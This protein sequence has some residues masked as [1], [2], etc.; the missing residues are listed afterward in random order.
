MSE[1]QQTTVDHFF[2]LQK[3]AVAVRQVTEKNASLARVADPLVAKQEDDDAESQARL[4]A[5]I[6]KKSLLA[7]TTTTTTTGASL[8]RKRVFSGPIEV[9]VII[10][11]PKLEA[12][13]EDQSQHASSPAK[14]SKTSPPPAP[15]I[16]SRTTISESAIASSASALAQLQSLVTPKGTSSLS[17]TTTTT[18]TR[19]VAP[20]IDDM[21]K[22]NRR[23]GGEKMPHSTWFYATYENSRTLGQILGTLADFA[24]MYMLV[25]R[26]DGLEVLTND[27]GK[28]WTFQLQVPATSFVCYRDLCD[29][30][31]SF[32]IMGQ[33]IK[34]FAR[35]CSADKTIT[36]CRRQNGDDDEP[37]DLFLCSPDG[38]FESGAVTRAQFK[39]YDMEARQMLPNSPHQYR[40]TMRNA[41][42]AKHLRL[43][44]AEASDICLEISASNFKMSAIDHEMGGD[45]NV[46]FPVKKTLAEAVERNGEC[47]YIERLASADADG[48][49]LGQL[50]HMR[51][52]GAYLER[53]THFACDVDVVQILMGLRNSPTLAGTKE[54]SLLG[55]AYDYGTGSEAAFGVRMWLAPEFEIN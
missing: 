46:N 13:E 18:K 34:R 20:N 23:P 1:H 17:T 28:V 21:R 4:K 2:K 48:V 45:Q 6:K 16:T 12:S 40:I 44:I 31:M 24:D 38:K 42:F 55:F 7:A 43:L 47:A 26:D 36:F 5:A 51:F 33:K 29:S 32:V 25:F 10:T 15:L 8:S 3:K 22:F 52:I 41:V 11:T 9:P 35:A 19:A 39:R 27:D 50:P 14:R 30:A 53:M 37:L 49:S 54:E